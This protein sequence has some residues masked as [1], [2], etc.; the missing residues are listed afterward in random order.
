MPLP[1]I[2]SIGNAE[3]DGLTDFKGGKFSL[4]N[5]STW[6]RCESDKNTGSTNRQM[7]KQNEWRDE[8]MHVYG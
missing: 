2:Q 4:P 8:Q 3:E 7:A 1:V 6:E 5:W